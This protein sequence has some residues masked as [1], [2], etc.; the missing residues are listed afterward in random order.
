MAEMSELKLGAI[1]TSPL[2]TVGF[3]TVVSWAFERDGVTI[4]AMAAVATAARR[5]RVCIGDS[6]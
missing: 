2:E 1:A 3:F 6:F 5:V 4:A